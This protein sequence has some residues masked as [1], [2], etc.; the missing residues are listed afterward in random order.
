MR[1]GLIT[2][3]YPP[4]QGGVADFTRE[5]GRALAAQGH[6]VFVL[7]DRQGV[8]LDDAGV[9]V[10][11]QV[12]NWN[13][14]GL[15]AVGRW[16]HA[17]RL[18]V[19]N[20]QYQTAAFRMAGM[21][22]LLPGR[23]A[24]VPFV[25]TFHDLLPPYLFPKVG[26]LRQRAVWG[27]AR[28]S[29]A[30]I[31]TNHADERTLEHLGGVPCLC[32]IPIGSNIEDA[33]PPDFDRAAWRARLGVGEDETLVGYFGFLNRSKGVDTLLNALQRA[34]ST[35]RPFTLL[36]IGGRTGASDPTNVAYAAEVDA[37]IAELGLAERVL[38]TGFVT[39]AEVSGYFACCDLCALPYNEGVSLRHGTF[40]AAIAHGC[41]VITTTPSYHLPELHNKENVYF[42]APQSVSGLAAALRTLATQP[43]VRAHLSAGARELA[44]LFAWDNIAAQTAALFA[45]LLAARQ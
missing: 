40:M 31:V 4:M 2:G 22:H 45:E 14:A 42:V 1:I 21:I 10:T 39:P 24:D 19:L 18:D 23:V 9:M 5:L 7:T 26:G 13:A 17:H 27:L 25:T 20:L 6:E 11:A 12:R 35:G 34:N 43:D 37:L 28:T 36:M 33:P 44:G 41:P 38:W 32:R 29:T 16:A 30:S 15:S 8:G 3:E